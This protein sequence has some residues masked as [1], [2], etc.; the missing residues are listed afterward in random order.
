MLALIRVLAPVTGPLG[1]HGE[2]LPN[3][4]TDLRIPIDE[5]KLRVGSP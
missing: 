3:A 1:S 4:R 2:R 5:V